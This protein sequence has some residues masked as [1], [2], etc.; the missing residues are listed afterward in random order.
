MPD[1]TIWGVHMGAEHGDA[2]LKQGYVAIGWPELGNLTAIGPSRDSFKAAYLKANPGAKPGN[3][4][5]SAGVPFRFAVEIKVGD[6]VV[7][8]S[9]S[10]RMVNIGR[11]AGNY[12]Y[13]PARPLYPNERPVTWLKQLP[14]AGFS[15]TALNE[16]G[17]AITLFRVS[18]TADEFTAALSGEAFEPTDIDEV[19]AERVTAQVEESTEDFVV[20][21]LKSAQTPYQ[22]EQF[23]A[24]LLTRMGYHARVTKASGDGGIDII[25]HRDELGFEPPII[26]VQCKQVLQSIG[27]PEVQQLHGAIE[28]GEH[29]LFVTLGTFTADART[30]ERTKP[31]M[32]LID[33][34]TLVELIYA[35]YERF[36][37]RYQMLLPLKRTYVP[38]AVLPTT[39]Q[40]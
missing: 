6:L 7:Y 40:N 10:D 13:D 9:K 37:P 33:G 18:T 16:I 3:V 26:K 28:H 27:R 23:V 39:G 12:R 19:S 31:N 24:H 4:A 14:R 17:S 11:V 22:F 25:A 21:R 35:H 15:Q 32:R 36:E 34:E 2:P 5:V 30:F 20:K 38:G 29:G 1:T 8:P